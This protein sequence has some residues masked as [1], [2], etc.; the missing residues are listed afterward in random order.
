MYGKLK[1]AMND[2]G[3][4]NAAISNRNALELYA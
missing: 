1:Q 4:G 2:P 3:G